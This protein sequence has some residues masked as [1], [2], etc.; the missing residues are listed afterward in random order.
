MESKVRFVL[1][2]LTILCSLVLVLVNN[3]VL[4][5]HISHIR[6]NTSISFEINDTCKSLLRKYLKLQITEA[7]LNGLISIC[8]TDG[9]LNDRIEFDMPVLNKVLKNLTCG[10]ILKK[11]INSTIS[12]IALASFPGSGNNMTRG[13]LEAVTG[14]EASVSNRKVLCPS[15]GY[16]FIIKTHR[17]NDIPQSKDCSRVNTHR[18]NYKKAIYILRN[19]YNALLAEYKRRRTFSKRFETKT[20]TQFEGDYFGARWERFVILQSKIWKE[21]T[22]YWLNTFNGPVHL[23]VYEK[24]LAYR[25]TEVY[26]LARFVNASITLETLLCTK[27][28]FIEDRKR[29]YVNWLSEISASEMF[30]V[31]MRKFV[32]KIILSTNEIVKLKILEEYILPEI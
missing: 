8:K 13:I 22:I 24:M 26:S 15:R 20:Q 17:T 6:Q 32:N 25:M 5:F 21:L 31:K 29:T 2:S 7:Q 19:P 4:F 10:I 28:N 18:L 23:V 12:L 27:S 11:L 16:A 1:C 30:D 9:Y 3:N 14:F